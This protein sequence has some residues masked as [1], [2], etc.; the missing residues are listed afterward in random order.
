MLIIYI[1]EIIMYLMNKIIYDT[2]KLNEFCV[3]LL[4]HFVYRNIKVRRY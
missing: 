4:F 1:D 3:I 2:L